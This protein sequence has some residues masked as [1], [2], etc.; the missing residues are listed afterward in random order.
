MHF[1]H[2]M[3]FYFRRGRKAVQTAKKI[4]AVYGDC[5]I[6]KRSTVRKWFARFRSGNFDLEDRE[7]SGRPAVVDDDQIETL[8]K[9]NPGHSTRDIAEVLHISHMSVVRHLKTLGYVNRYD[10]WVPHNLT[11]KNLIDRISICYSLLKR[12]RN[13]PFLKRTITGDEKWIVYNNV[14]R[15]RPWEKRDEST[16]TTPATDL[17]PK[18]VMLC[19]WWDWKGIVY[20]ELLPQ[21]QMLNSD[22][23]CSQL[24]RLKAAIDEKRPE[25]ANQK[26]VIFHQ[27]SARPHISLQTRQKLIQL[28][29][30]VLLHPPYSPDL[31]PSNYHLFRSLQNSLDGRNSVFFNSVKTT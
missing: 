16:I 8:I 2:L 27:D 13:N 28:G 17:H 21:N 14:E 31:A 11:E 7:R 18:K 26:G 25:L 29:W 9:N 10:V 5:A 19:I 6:A 4:C 24:D 30:D 1:R 12:N 3:L 20:Y 22:K 15:K 23:Y